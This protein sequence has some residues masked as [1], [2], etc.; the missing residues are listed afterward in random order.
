VHPLPEGRQGH[1][2]RLTARLDGA[3]AHLEL[4]RAQVND[5]N[6]FRD[7]VAAE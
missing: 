6:A 4:D 5:L 1:Q 3:L 7:D 2:G